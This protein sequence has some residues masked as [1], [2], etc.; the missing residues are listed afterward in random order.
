MKAEANKYHRLLQLLPQ[1]IAVW[2]RGNLQPTIFLRR[3]CVMTKR[4]KATALL[5]TQASGNKE[6]KRSP[7]ERKWSSYEATMQTG[8]RCSKPYANTKRSTVTRPF[9]WTPDTRS[10]GSGYRTNKQRTARASSRFIGTRNWI[11]LVL[12][13][14]TREKRH[15][16]GYIDVLLP[17]KR[18]TTGRRRCHA[19]IPRIVS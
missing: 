8:K 1:L 11:R 16:W 10:S 12:H 6:G 9:H 13:G 17:I 19:S 2:A 3:K 5:R 4:K 15:G 14:N 18:S 7:K